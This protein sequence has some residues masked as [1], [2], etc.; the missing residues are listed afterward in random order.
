MR[1]HVVGLLILALIIGTSSCKNPDEGFPTFPVP[2]TPFPP[3]DDPTR[4][5]DRDQPGTGRGLDFTPFV[6]PGGYDRLLDIAFAPSFPEIG[7]AILVLDASGVHVFNSVGRRVHFQGHSDK[8]GVAPFLPLP[9]F[10]LVYNSNSTTTAWNMD[11]QVL[12][13]DP[14]HTTV[15]D[16]N[17]PSLDFFTSVPIGT[18]LERAGARESP[19]QDAASGG[20][21]PVGIV[22]D[23]YGNLW[24]R[25]TYQAN[26]PAQNCSPVQP[27][28]SGCPGL[29][30]Y[31]RGINGPRAN[32]S[33]FAFPVFHI[34]H[35]SASTLT[36]NFPGG[37]WGALSTMLDFDFDSQNRMV[38][39]VALDDW[40]GFTDPVPDWFFYTQAN[41]PPPAINVTRVRGFIGGNAG[42]DNPHVRFPW[43]VL[44]DRSTDTVYVADTGND[45]I[46]EFDNQ[47][48]F[49]RTIRGGEESLVR[50]LSV[51]VFAGPIDMELDPYGRLFIIDRGTDPTTGEAV[52]DLQI[53]YTKGKK[54]ALFSTVRGKVTDI[55][56]GAP[57]FQ[58]SVTL[59][60]F[61]GPITALT[62]ERGE[63]AFTGVDPGQRSI[64][65]DKPGYISQ[66]REFF[67]NPG[68]TVTLDFS[69]VPRSG[70]VNGSVSGRVVDDDTGL[71]ISG[72][73]VTITDLGL[74]TF[75]GGQGLFFIG[76]VPPGVHTL[77]VTNPGYE[78]LSK[79]FAVAAGQNSDVGDLRLKP[80]PNP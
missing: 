30:N 12:G 59:F 54:P 13:Q 17:I 11:F 69:L 64:A 74:T 34:T 8:V 55:R 22:W 15:C 71:P 42:A 47:A 7:P 25:G 32:E 37:V 60:G 51:P 41:A 4:P 31:V 57:I 1:Y 27:C 43:G 78:P 28:E 3:G 77:L 76:N 66:S 26:N 56:T 65:V 20:P 23:I 68:E 73:R 14:F 62:D 49:R 9:E 58:A 6:P 70:T 80:V 38:F 16:Q 36:G 33:G 45:R 72:A 19:P 2:G 39:T 79:P 52:Q 75:S 50:N 10:Y 24:M 46:I 61:S 53:I 18:G 5:G 67:A 29:F 21:G 48:N 35:D 63:Y 40:I 44:I